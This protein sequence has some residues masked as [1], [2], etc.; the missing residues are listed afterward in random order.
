MPCQRAVAGSESWTSACVR[1]S[2]VS[3]VAESESWTGAC[4]SHVSPKN[5]QLG[6]KVGPAPVPRQSHQSAVA[7]SESWTSACASPNLVSQVAESESRTSACASHRSP[8]AS[9]RIGKLGRLLCHVSLAKTHQPGQKVGP[10]FVSGRVFVLSAQWQN[11]K[12]GP[13]PVP[14]ISRQNQELS[15]KVGPALVPCQSRQKALA[16]SESWTSA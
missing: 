5:Q 11:Q 1:P 12:V 8:E 7:K 10:V 15:Q 9:S 14:A 6:Q 3:Q 13:A 16:E 2:L 4:A